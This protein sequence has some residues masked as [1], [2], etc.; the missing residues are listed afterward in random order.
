[1][2]QGVSYE[3]TVLT[4]THDVTCHKNVLYVMAAAL[5]PKLIHNYPVQ[6]QMFHFVTMYFIMGFYFRWNSSH[7]FFINV[8]LSI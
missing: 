5:T 1:M 4:T 8:F 3:V 2:T 7:P 6:T